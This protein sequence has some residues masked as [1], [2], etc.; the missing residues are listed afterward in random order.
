MLFTIR[1]STGVTE[2]SPEIQEDKVSGQGLYS[3]LLKLKKEC[4]SFMD[5]FFLG[6]E[7]VYSQELSYYKHS[8]HSLVLSGTY[9]RRS[10][11]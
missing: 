11:T 10:V 2:I 4:F 9:V 8:L 7:K 3:P 5:F 1:D 6:R